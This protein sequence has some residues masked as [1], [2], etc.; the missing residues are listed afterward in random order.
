MWWPHTHGE[1]TTYSYRIWAK[2]NNQSIT[3]K[4]GITGFKNVT[5]DDSSSEL[6]V[7][8]TKVFCRGTCWTVSDY[9]HLN[10]DRDALAA[11][12]DLLKKAGV[13]MIR[14]GGTM[15]YESDDFYQ[16]CDQMGIMV[17]QDFMFAS[18]DY[19]FDDS[20]FLENAQIESVQQNQRLSDH[21]CIAVYCGNTDVEAQ[22]AMYGID[23]KEWTHSFFSEW[24]ATTCKEY[25]P[26]IPYFASSPTGGS[27]PVRRR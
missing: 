27:Q 4:T 9:H 15:I 7:N 13:N 3:L 21:P 12:L 26:D 20:N 17:W 5:F 24:L 18:M 2:S 8:G 6:R 19:P 23:S 25:K 14:V 11:H 16:L 10:T 22:A 1:P